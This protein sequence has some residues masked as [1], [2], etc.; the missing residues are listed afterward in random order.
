MRI[1]I[2]DDSELV[3]R[4][5]RGLLS[6]EASR[7]ICGE[8]RNGFSRMMSLR[9]LEDAEEGARTSQNVCE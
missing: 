2:A 6:A 5:V 3:R 1:L 9:F 7:E 8:A 4:A